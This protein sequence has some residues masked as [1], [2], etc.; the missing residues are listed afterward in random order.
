LEEYLKMGLME[1]LTLLLGA[2]VVTLV[3]AILT[4]GKVLVDR[5]ATGLV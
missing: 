4:L 2:L 5:L 3:G 1:A